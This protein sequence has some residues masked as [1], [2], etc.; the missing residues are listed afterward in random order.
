MFKQ[1]LNT[2]IEQSATSKLET[3]VDAQMAIDNQKQP[4]TK[5]TPEQEINNT[6][7]RERTDVDM[8]STEVLKKQNNNSTPTKKDHGTERNYLSTSDVA[9]ELFK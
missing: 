9:M 3:F 7:K 5:I 8:D 6:R 4:K 2:K 1:L